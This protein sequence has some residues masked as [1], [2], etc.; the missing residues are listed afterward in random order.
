MK[1]ET[2]DDA[3]ADRRH[4]EEV[5]GPGITDVVPKES[6]PGLGLSPSIGLH[7]VLA[8]RVRRGRVKSEELQMAVDS[9]GAPQDVFPAESADEHLHLAADRGPSSLSTRLPSPPESEQPLVPAGD[10]VRLH[11]AG[12][13]TPAV[14]PAAP[15]CAHSPIKASASAR[16]SKSSKL[17]SLPRRTRTSARRLSAFSWSPNC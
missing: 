4:R 8:N 3:E 13:G 15:P 5:D 12:T 10:G 11:Q 9:L 7:H 16:K 1:S 2:V 17:D 6:Q 14:P